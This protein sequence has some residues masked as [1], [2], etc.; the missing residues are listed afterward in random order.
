MTFR[1]SLLVSVG[2]NPISGAPR[3]CR[4]DVAALEIAR[5]LPGDLTVLH[6]G[7]AGNPGLADYL[8]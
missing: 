6:A 8:A 1:A 7:D 3:A 4:N 5:G 2:R